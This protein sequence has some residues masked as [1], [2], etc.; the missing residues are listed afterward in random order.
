M[1]KIETFRA[2]VAASASERKEALELM[3]RIEQMPEA[4]AEE[5][6]P[7]AQAMIRLSGETR[8]SL[9]KL[10]QQNARLSKTL[11]QAREDLAAERQAAQ[12]AVKELV[13][14][15]EVER[16]RSAWFPWMVLAASL[17][18][19]WLTMWLMGQSWARALIGW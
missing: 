13:Q 19:P 1:S 7:V 17:A 8:S 11:D 18:S 3:S 10:E 6:I 5:L 4:L 16:A 14:A 2:S 9:K 15:V 12:A